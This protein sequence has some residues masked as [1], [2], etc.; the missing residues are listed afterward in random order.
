MI[1]VQAKGGNDRLS[2]IQTQ[3]DIACCHEK[4]PSLM[5]RPLSAQFMRDGVIAI[6]ELTMQENRIRVVDEKHYKLVPSGQITAEELQ[7]YSER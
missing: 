3:Q 1:P 2:V 5:C 7:S 4:F 6:F